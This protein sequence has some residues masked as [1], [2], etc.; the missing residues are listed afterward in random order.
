MCWC[1]FSTLS[2]IN[3]MFLIRLFFTIIVQYHYIFFYKN[4]LDAEFID[5]FI[6]V[7]KFLILSTMHGKYSSIVTFDLQGHNFNNY[8]NCLEIILIKKIRILKGVW[9]LKKNVW[10]PSTF[11]HLER[12]ILGVAAT[13]RE[14]DPLHI[15]YFMNFVHIW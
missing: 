15:E 4:I 3:K 14:G 7:L 9:K 10:L 2:D 12:T 8:Y 5:I 13:G 6:Q 1:Y 11:L